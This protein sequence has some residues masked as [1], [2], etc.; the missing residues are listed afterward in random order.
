[1]AW[2]GKRRVTQNLPYILLHSIVQSFTCRRSILPR[3]DSK[4]VRVSRKY[5]YWRK[6]TIETRPPD[7][8]KKKHITKM[9]LLPLKP[10]PLPGLLWVAPFDF[11]P[12]NLA[13]CT[14]ACDLWL[15]CDSRPTAAAALVNI[16]FRGHRQ[17]IDWLAQPTKNYCDSKKL[18]NRIGAP[19]V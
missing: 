9:F 13:C 15:I 1:M 5:R 17:G 10:P 14:P 16:P 19:H 8:E 3:V 4:K 2:W 7:K 11:G 6:T 18:Q 12:A